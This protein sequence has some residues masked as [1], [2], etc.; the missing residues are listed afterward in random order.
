MFDKTKYTQFFKATN[1]K[2]DYITL[3]NS[4]V[5]RTEP[6]RMYF[7]ATIVNSDLVGL[8]FF[9]IF[10]LAFLLFL[11]PVGASNPAGQFSNPAG[12]SFTLT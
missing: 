11:A 7:V 2:C 4:N 8:L 6:L 10:K 5:L 3:D 1:R 9:R 12:Q